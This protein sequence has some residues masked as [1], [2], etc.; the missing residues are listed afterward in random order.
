M[1]TNWAKYSSKQ[2]QPWRLY[3]AVM[4][5]PFTFIRCY[6]RGTSWWVYNAVD[7]HAQIQYCTNQV[8]ISHNWNEHILN[9]RKQKYT[10]EPITNALNSMERIGRRT[11]LESHK[12]WKHTCSPW[13]T[14]Q[15]V[16]R[17]DHTVLVPRVLWEFWRQTMPFQ[18]KFFNFPLHA[19]RNL[20]LTR[21]QRSS[22]TIPVCIL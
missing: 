1:T 16:F 3:Q 12:T 17:H 9:N 7:T 8:P 20:V 13:N 18:I 10:S 4:S 22:P 5:I 14:L 6:Q 11:K 19:Q 21:K 2:V 15:C